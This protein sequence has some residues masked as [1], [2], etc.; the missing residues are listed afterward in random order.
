MA[1]KVTVAK[2]V[3]VPRGREEEMRKRRGSSNAGEYKTVS[4]ND[5]AG[6][7]GGASPFSYPINTKSRARS[8]LK[9]AHFAPDPEGIKR[10][11]YRK[12]PDLRKDSDTKKRR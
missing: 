5:F 11:V 10:A 6:S 4:R 2:G 1:R 12:Y 7:S 8:A 3:K 9:L